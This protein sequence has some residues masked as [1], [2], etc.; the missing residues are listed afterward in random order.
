M[1]RRR[2]SRIARLAQVLEQLVHVWRQSRLLGSARIARA[3][4]PAGWRGS[5]V[6]KEL[7]GDEQVALDDL[8]EEDG[9]DGLE[10]VDELWRR[11]TVEVELD[12]LC[13]IAG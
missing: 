1:Q 9:S 3:R 6:L 13:P 11:R 12:A 10:E 8:V 4:V 5:L 2:V 7:R